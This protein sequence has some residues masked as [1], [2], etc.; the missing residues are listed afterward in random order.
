VQR[1]GEKSG[2]GQVY[3]LVD[4][5][6]GFGRCGGHGGLFCRDGCFGG[7][8]DRKKMQTERTRSDGH[9]ITITKTRPPAAPT[10][11]CYLRIEPDFFF[12]P[13]QV[14]ID[15]RDFPRE[16]YRC[17]GVFF[18][19]SRSSIRKR[20]FSFAAT[21]RSGMVRAPTVRAYSFP[22]ALIIVTHTR[23]AAASR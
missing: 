1:I 10:S 3:A 16:S 23:A 22:C 19:P 9:S 2:A 7:Q 6:Q 15:L 17:L 20:I 8:T 14:D 21:A 4:D 13:K 18:F 12:A 11:G 5:V